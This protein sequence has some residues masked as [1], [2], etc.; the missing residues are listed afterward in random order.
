MAKF[1]GIRMRDLVRVEDPDAGG[2]LTLVFRD[3]GALKIRIVD[4]ALAS[5]SIPE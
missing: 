1:D 2:G 4:G 5:E 3:G